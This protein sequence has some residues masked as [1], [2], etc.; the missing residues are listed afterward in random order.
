MGFISYWEGHAAHALPDHLATLS[1]WEKHPTTEIPKQRHVMAGAWD[2]MDEIFRKNI[3]SIIDK[4]E[5]FLLMFW[6]H[7]DV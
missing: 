1:G 6:S 4:S 5:G 7:S 2:G 3:V